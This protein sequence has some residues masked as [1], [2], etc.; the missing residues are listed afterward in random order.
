MKRKSGC[1]TPL[2]PSLLHDST[3]LIN[4]DYEDDNKISANANT[5]QNNYSSSPG[6]Q[7]KKLSKVIRVWHPDTLTENIVDSDLI[8]I[9][10]FKSVLINETTTADY[11]RN[12]V[13]GK[14][15]IDNANQYRIY[16][17]K[18]QGK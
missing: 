7:I 6:A 9:T 12:F 18:N 1:G 11:C 15:L 10:S 2:N 13:A 4:F 3:E 14:L 5:A 17:I 16:S 8:S